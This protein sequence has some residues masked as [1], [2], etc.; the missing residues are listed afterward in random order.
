MIDLADSCFNGVKIMQ[1]PGR[2]QLVACSKEQWKQGKNEY[3]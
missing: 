3:L 1:E 2:D